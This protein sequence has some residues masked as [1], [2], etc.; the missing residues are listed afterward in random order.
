MDERRLRYFLAVVSEDGV[1]RAAAMLHVAQP[2]VSQTLRSLESELGVALFDRV[3]R[4]L[5]LTSAGHELVAHAR[6][7]LRSIDEARNAVAGVA[8]LR[9]GTLELAALATLAVDPMAALI[10]RFRARHPGVEVRVRA[11]DSA[12]TVGSLLRDGTCEIGAAH[13][14]PPEGGL[15]A[16]KLGEQELLFVLPPSAA[17]ERSG[18]ILARELART[19]LVVTPAGTSTRT[20]LEQALAAAAVTPRIAVEVTAREAIVPLVLAGAGAALLPAP[21][22]DEAHRRG[23]IVRPARPQ[24]TRPIG[25]VHRDAVLSPAARTF[26]AL[27]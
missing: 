22:A 26:L 16:H 25:L 24:I 6:Q 13:L 20:L 18:P 3:G 14:P 10:G 15:L 8:Q 19:P 4:G 17:G 7:I 23:A 2:S 21:L 1:T 11:P 27:A 9:T 12:H 5:R